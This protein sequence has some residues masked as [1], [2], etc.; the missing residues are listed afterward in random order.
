MV[1]ETGALSSVADFWC[2]ADCKI[3]DLLADGFLGVEKADAL[4]SKVVYPVTFDVRS[5]IETQEQVASFLDQAMKSDLPI[6]E[7][8]IRE[9]TKQ[10]QRAI[11]PNADEELLATI[12]EET[13]NADFG[14]TAVEQ[15]D[16]TMA[17]MANAP[18]QATQRKM[19]Q[20]MQ[21]TM[22]PASDM[23]EEG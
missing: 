3:V 1:P 23:T 13:D 10:L 6:S 16:P 18:Q 4:E 20:S 11:L 22:Q 8:C 5:P 14:D 7:T 17:N 9:V 21:K 15:A 19:Q 2:A 12:D